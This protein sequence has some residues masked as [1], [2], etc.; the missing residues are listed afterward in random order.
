MIQ[1]LRQ[2][3]S[4]LVGILGRESHLRHVDHFDAICLCVRSEQHFRPERQPWNFDSGGQPAAG[5]SRDTISEAVLESNDAL[6]SFATEMK[7]Q[8][9]GKVLIA[10]SAD[11]VQREPVSEVT[12]GPRDYVLGGIRLR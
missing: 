9:V 12:E 3:P 8:V 2:V 1:L 5:K 11:A 7:L 6:S 4:P 10:A